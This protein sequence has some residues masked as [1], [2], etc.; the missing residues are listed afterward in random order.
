MAKR[1]HPVLAYL[2][3]SAG[4]TPTQSKA[5]TANH[6]FKSLMAELGLA[7]AEQKCQP[8]AKQFTWLGFTIDT[9]TMQIAVPQEKLQEIRQECDTWARRTKVKKQQLQ[10]FLGKILH[11]APCIRPHA[12]SAPPG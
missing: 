5:L 8:P 1:G 2:N 12:C 4:Y 7:L 6:Y 11:V 9:A 3:D 10:S